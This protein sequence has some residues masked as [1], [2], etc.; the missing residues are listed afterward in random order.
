MCA[1]AR[2]PS[3]LD[4]RSQTTPRLSRA[5]PAHTSSPVSA[6]GVFAPLVVKGM[7]YTSLEANLMSV[8]P[9]IVGAFGI[10]AFVR[11]SHRFTRRT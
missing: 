3:W 8:P 7:G 4:V 10:V 2:A 5:D 6:F 11:L 9:F 1:E